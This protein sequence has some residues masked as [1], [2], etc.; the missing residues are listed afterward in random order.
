MSIVPHTSPPTLPA[1]QVDALERETAALQIRIAKLSAKATAAREE[2]ASP[3]LG[4][5][6]AA[7]RAEAE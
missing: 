1:L 4:K 3:M 2:L 6:S 7:E 5:L